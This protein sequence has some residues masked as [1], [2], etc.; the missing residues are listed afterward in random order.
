[1]LSAN[2]LVCYCHSLG[3]LVCLDDKTVKFQVE[4]LNNE[5]DCS[6]HTMTVVFSAHHYY[7]TKQ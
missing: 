7:F 4:E 5:C 1:M 2:N 6:L 3:I